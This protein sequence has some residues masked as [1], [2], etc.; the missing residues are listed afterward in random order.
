MGLT[1]VVYKRPDAMHFPPGTDLDRMR[2]D[3]LTGEV[4]FDSYPENLPPHE[5]IEA[6]KRFGNISMIAYLREQLANTVGDATHT[7]LL[8]KKVLY[9]GTHGGDVIPLSE[10]GLLKEEVSLVRNRIACQSSPEL[11]TFLSSMD[12]LIAA[13]ERQGNPI[14]FL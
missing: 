4:Y 1:A 11:E 14:V 3:D 9:N 8:I 10:R 7:L 6:K 5:T 13:S 12:E 2:V